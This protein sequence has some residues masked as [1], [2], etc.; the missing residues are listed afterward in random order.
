MAGRM[1]A[2]SRYKLYVGKEV[3]ES[4]FLRTHNVDVLAYPDAAQVPLETKLAWFRKNPESYVIF[5]DE[6]A[7]RVIGYISVYPVKP[8]F[9]L[10]YVNGKIDF[11]NIKPS[12][13]CR[14]KDNHR[15]WLYGWSCAVLPEYQGKPIKDLF[16]TSKYHGVKVFKILNEG[17]VELFCR[18]AK[19]KIYIDKI[20]GEGYGPKGNEYLK[21]LALARMSV[22]KKSDAE[23]YLGKFSV[24]AYYKCRNYR[25]LQEAYAGK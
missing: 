21:N 15:Y 9:A 11:K 24:D 25:Q 23:I 16:S 5:Y 18:L 22:R 3:T 7:R 20:F 6:A 14:Y 8:S 13:I 12:S 19:R 1:V 17:L 4:L 10:K 2:K